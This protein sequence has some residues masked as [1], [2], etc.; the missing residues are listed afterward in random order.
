MRSRA[1]AL[2]L[3]LL[4]ALL[5]VANAQSS[6][7][8]RAS[9]PSSATRDKRKSTKRASRA[10]VDPTAVEV[11]PEKATDP[12]EDAPTAT[13]TPEPASA[14]VEVA[15]EP[16][17]EPEPEPTPT[18]TPTPTAAAVPARSKSPAPAD[19]AIDPNAPPPTPIK[20]TKPTYRAFPGQEPGKCAYCKAAAHRLQTS[21]Y[22]AHR[23]HHDDDHEELEKGREQ[24]KKIP[25][26]ALA[27]TMKGA[28][29]DEDYW[30]HYAAFNIETGGVVLAGPGLD[31]AVS[32]HHESTR[33]AGSHAKDLKST[34][35]A[36]A[37][38]AEKK[39]HF[40]ETFW[41]KHLAGY[42]RK[43]YFQEK[44]CD[45]ACAAPHDEL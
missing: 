14:A 12:A 24:K 40:Y 38:D 17:P 11:A 19:P 16:E 34:C 25:D 8:G 18:P 36:V 9:S 27:M 26:D 5:G 41:A 43:W 10:S 22:A 39:D 28:C 7:S 21:F 37:A 42:A 31:W 13:P 30:S 3:F 33:V 6:G 32:D 35:V 1:K 4:L 15:P 45:V 29:D 20:K 44:F 23:A 2:L